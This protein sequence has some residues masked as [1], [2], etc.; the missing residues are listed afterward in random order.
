MKTPKTV[1]TKRKHIRFTPDLG[2]YV[3]LLIEEKK[4]KKIIPHVALLVEEA[5]GG[6]QIA[7]TSNI[8]PKKGARLRVKVGRLDPCWSEV[9]W[10]KDLSNKIT[11]VGLQYEDKSKE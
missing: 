6:C 7:M 3:I 9:K 8:A 11:S 4:T 2:D 1:R 5:F 10:V